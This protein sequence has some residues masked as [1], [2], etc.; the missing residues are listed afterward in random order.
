MESNVKNFNYN[1][2]FVESLPGFTSYKAV[3]L[4]IWTVDPGIG[5]FRCTDGRERLIPSCQLDDEFYNSLPPRPK[6][7][8]FKGNGVFF[9]EP[10]QS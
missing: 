5:L 9:G 7:D 8:P 3:E 2:F 1:G 10:A 6:L 4:V